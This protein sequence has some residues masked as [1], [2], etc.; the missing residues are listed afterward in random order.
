MK[1]T[2]LLST[3]LL[4]AI[5]VLPSCKK[6]IIYVDK[7]LGIEIPCIECADCKK[8]EKPNGTYIAGTTNSRY[9]LGSTCC[10]YYS[11]TLDSTIITNECRYFCIK[12]PKSMSETQILAYDSLILDL[13]G[14]WFNFP[15]SCSHTFS[16]A[17]WANCD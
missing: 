10:G 15:D 9:Y 16:K 14:Y 11:E 1:F 2:L 3:A 12:W 6:E 8:Y 17:V 4:I 13:N 7:N 5:F